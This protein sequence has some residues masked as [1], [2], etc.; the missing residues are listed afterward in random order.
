MVSKDHRPDLKQVVLELVTSHD[1]RIPLMMKSFD[2][3]ASDSTIFKERCRTFLS[4]FKN[5]SFPKMIVG[6]SKLYDEENRAY[7]PQ[8]NVIT[9]IPGTYSA[10]KEAIQEVLWQKQWIG[11]D[12]QNAYWDESAL[13]GGAVQ[14]GRIQGL[15]D[16][17]TEGRQRICCGRKSTRYDGK[18]GP[19]KGEQLWRQVYQV[20]G[21]IISAPEKRNADIAQR[22]CYVIG[23]NVPADERD[24]RAIIDAYKNKNDSIE[25]GFRF[26]K[27]PYFFASSF[28]LKKPSRIRGLL[29]IMPLSLLVYSIAQRHLRKQVLEQNETFPNPIKQPIQN[30]TMRWIFQLLEGIDVIY[31]KINGVLHKKIT[32]IS[33]LKEKILSFFSQ[34]ILNIY[35]LNQQI[36]QTS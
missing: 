28:F 16:G 7:L 14:I 36:S 13:V 17:L 24:A 18:G 11:G 21:V 1:G 34:H 9:R 32:G 22:A 6:D 30:P 20:F 27:D 3:N 15:E 25:R 33:D 12:S 10:E 8:L 19:K 31:V 4:S 5:T 2:G 26:L 29:M 23:T 35:S